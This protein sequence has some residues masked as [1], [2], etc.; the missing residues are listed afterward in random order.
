MMLKKDL[1]NASVIGL[2]VAGIF[3]GIAKNT[4]LLIPHIEIALFVFPVLSVV[5]MFVASLLAKKFAVILQASRFLLVGGLNTFIDLGILNL[6]IFTGGTAVGIWF[7]VFKGIAFIVAVL[8]SYIWNKH[9][10]FDT[11]TQAQGKEFIQFLLVS[12][13]G[14]IINVSIA[15]FLV[16]VLGATDTISENMWA[17]V[18]AVT[19]TFTGMLWNFMGY[20]LIVF[21]K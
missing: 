4:G 16:N 20:K 6:L 14:F 18:A 15:S 8:N 21:K 2:V 11:K 7:S 19:A 10:T 12:I 13:V 9:W 3:L 1:I 17:N 5:G